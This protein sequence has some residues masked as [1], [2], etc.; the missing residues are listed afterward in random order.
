MKSAKGKGAARVSQEALKPNDRLVFF[1]GSCS[2]NKVM[3][4]CWLFFCACLLFY[5]GICG[6]KMTIQGFIPCASLPSSPNLKLQLLFNAWSATLLMSDVI[7]SLVDTVVTEFHCDGSY[8][9]LLFSER[10]GSGKLLLL[11]LTVAVKGKLRGRRRPRKTQINQ[12]GLLVLFLSSCMYLFLFLR[13]KANMAFQFSEYINS[14]H[15]DVTVRS[16][17]KPSR[18]RIPM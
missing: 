8:I 11:S 6:F 4:S 3:K 14:C 10:L 13:Q 5:V 17:G 16:S 1:S 15:F 7:Y 2:R 18:K 12:R 9:S